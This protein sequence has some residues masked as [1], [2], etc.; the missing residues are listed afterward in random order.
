MDDRKYLTPEE[1]AQR[2]RGAVSIG[3]GRELEK[4]VNN[5]VQIEVERRF[6][7]SMGEIG[8]GIVGV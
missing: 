6:L 7:K 3:K 1:V 5:S 4:D 8:C 2:Y